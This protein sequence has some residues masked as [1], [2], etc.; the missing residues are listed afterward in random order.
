MNSPYQVTTI[1]LLRHGQCKGGEIYRGITDV[2]LTDEGWQQ[3]NNSINSSA[4]FPW[5]YII[6][7]PLKRC[8]DFANL[9]SSKS[10]IDV[11]IVNGLRELDFGEWEGKLITEVWENDTEQ[12]KNFTQDPINYSPPNGETLINAQTRVLKAWREILNTYRGQ[13]IL[14]VQHG[15]TMRLLLAHFLNIPLSNILRI[16]VPYAAISRV[17][18]YH[19]HDND[20]PMLEFHNG[21]L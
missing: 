5:N 21:S 1:D 2:A 17:K 20:Y 18:I 7:S 6:S 4:I 10:N 16:E 14:L 11:A 15:G 13:H 9:I 3:M 12:V 19:D 8:L